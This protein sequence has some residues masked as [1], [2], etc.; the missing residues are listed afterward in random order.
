MKPSLTRYLMCPT[1][2][3]DLRLDDERLGDGA[4]IVDGALTCLRCAHAYG[5]VRGIP[6]FPLASLEKIT[7]VTQRTQRTYAFTWRS[8]GES[9][10]EGEW[11]KDSYRYVEMIPPEL[12]SGTGKVGLDAGCGA[13]HDLLRMARGGAEIIG[14]D[15]SDG[16]ET[17]YRLTRHF[18]NVHVVQGDLNHTPF[19]P[20][21]F[22]F[23]Y[24]FGV[25]HHLPEPLR[26]FENL[27]RLLKPG[28]PLITYLYED[29]SDR[30]RVERGIL[31]GIR[32][33]RRVTSHL[34]AG[35]LY[36][37]CCL[38]APVVWVSCSVPARL[39]TPVVPRLAHRIPFRHTLRWNVLAS[40]LFD[41]FAPPVEWRYSKDGV[42][43]LYRTVGLDEVETHRYRGWVSWGC[44]TM[45]AVAERRA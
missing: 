20:R 38:A 1:C 21:Q 12:T 30:S 45:P 13:G 3:G 44:R 35:V 32:A 7:S 36:A 15:L 16:V 10:V 4:E 8:F 2:H 27:S 24:S 40:D 11:E 26:G 23:I 14:F 25:L 29:F 28:A 37:L 43:A 6:R 17:A 39:L 41:R 33:L 9:H 22:D 5:I 42:Q 19:K 34:P 31:A 18:P